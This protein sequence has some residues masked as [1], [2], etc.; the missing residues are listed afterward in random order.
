[1]SERGPF[2]L[3]EGWEAGDAERRA[4][5]IALP[6]EVALTVELNGQ[7]QAV[8]MALPGME[9]ELAVGFCL[10]EGL[11]AS[12][13]D[14]FLVHFCQDEGESGGA[15]VRI[16]ARPEAVAPVGT[17]RRLVLSGCGS[18]EM[19][20]A[21]LGLPALPPPA[22]PLLEAAAVREM[23]RHLRRHPGLY[24]KSGGVHAAALFSFR[25]EIA[26][27]A[28]DIG[29][30]NAVD[31]A[32]GAAVMRRLSP[33]DHVLLMTGRASHEVVAKA[34]RLGVPIV[35]SLSVATSLAVELAREGN[36]TLLGRLARERFLLYTH[37]ERIALQLLPP[38]HQEGRPA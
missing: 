24:R 4:L 14:I 16:Q 23:A 19:N 1:M 2:R 35:G 29:R 31:K 12:F 11:V 5:E 3:W 17:G 13:A 7:V 18:V 36:C 9:R 37:P 38:A 26:V 33:A 15:T 10:S 32:L 20:R 25:G 22:G 30:H 6:A 8:L 27:V 21:S 28:E 34:L